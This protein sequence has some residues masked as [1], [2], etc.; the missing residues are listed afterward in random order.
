VRQEGGA[1]GVIAL[2][3]VEGRLG[4]VELGGYDYLY[5]TTIYLSIDYSDFFRAKNLK[6][7][8]KTLWCFENQ[9]T[10]AKHICVLLHLC[11]FN[12][13]GLFICTERNYPKA[14]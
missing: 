4:I 10:F 12:L 11:V 9:N 14:T 6:S 2:M 13:L 7:V 3:V 1:G 8:F 5:H